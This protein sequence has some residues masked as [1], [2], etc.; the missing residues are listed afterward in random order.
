MSVRE[1]R[2]MPPH[3]IQRPRILYFDSV[4]IITMVAGVVAVVAIALLF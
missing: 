1:A 3:I 4:E 2:N